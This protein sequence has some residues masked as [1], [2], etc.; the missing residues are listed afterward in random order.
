[1]TDLY[2]VIS[3]LPIFLLSYPRQINQTAAHLRCEKTFITIPVLVLAFRQNLSGWIT[4]PSQDPVFQEFRHLKVDFDRAA[5][6]L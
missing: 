6:G 5:S 3:F 2:G 4:G 1:L